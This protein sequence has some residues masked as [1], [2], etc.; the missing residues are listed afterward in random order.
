MRDN[1]LPI[2]SNEAMANQW[3]HLGTLKCI[4]AK[5][6]TRIAPSKLL[7]RGGQSVISKGECRDVNA[8]RES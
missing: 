5:M 4:P 1:D 8:E 3:T 6:T 2:L 7:V